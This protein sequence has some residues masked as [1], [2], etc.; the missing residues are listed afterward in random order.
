MATLPT[1]I[2]LPS[3]QTDSTCPTL[4]NH[5]YLNGESQ[6]LAMWRS[7]GLHVK[8]IML[9]T[10]QVS[11]LLIRNNYWIRNSLVINEPTKMARCSGRNAYW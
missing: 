7:P 8:G 4:P 1:A 3:H 5:G 9:L 6:G 10:Q 11:P 2:P